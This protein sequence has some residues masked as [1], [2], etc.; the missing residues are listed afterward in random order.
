MPND[1]CNYLVIKF[2][3]LENLNNFKNKYLTKSNE[4]EDE[5][6]FEKVIPSPKTKEECPANCIINKGSHIE[7]EAERPWFDWYKW[8]WRNWGTKWNSY[9]NCI[10]VAENNTLKL[11]FS[12]AWDPAIPVIKALAN[13]IEEDFKYTY[14]EC[15]NCIA[16]EI[17]RENGEISEF[18]CD[19]LSDIE[20]RQF[21]LDNRLEDK[22]FLSEFYIIKDGKIIRAKEDEEE[23]NNG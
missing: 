6:D 5:F 17:V 4:N 21:L 9:D 12:T 2:K 7:L 19:G 15:G 13:Q 22:D 16:G 23:T 10:N 11:S 3:S 14:Y 18:D 20:Y 8:N 1:C